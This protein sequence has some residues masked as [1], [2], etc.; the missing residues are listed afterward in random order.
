MN[1]TQA[2]KTLLKEIW[3]EWGFLFVAIPIILLLTS[4][5]LALYGFIFIVATLTFFAGIGLGMIILVLSD[6]W[7][8]LRSSQ[9]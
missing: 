9:Q 5:L 6:R 4:F 1:R 3:R 7:E 2:T 8:E